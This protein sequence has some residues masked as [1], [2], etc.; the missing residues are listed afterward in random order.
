MK[1]LMKKLKIIVYL[2]HEATKCA[3]KENFF[4]FSND[5]IFSVNWLDV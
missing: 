2:K 3:D 1:K 5:S 4:H